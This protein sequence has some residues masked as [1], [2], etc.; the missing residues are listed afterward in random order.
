ME[1]RRREQTRK[2]KQQ[3]KQQRRNQRETE[4]R[5]NPTGTIDKDADLKDMVPGPQPGQ[6]IDID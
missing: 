2:Q 5:N 3:D 4:K 1:K 6:I